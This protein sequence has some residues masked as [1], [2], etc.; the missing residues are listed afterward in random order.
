MWIG[1]LSI[2]SASRN[3]VID[4]VRDA[5]QDTGLIGNVLVVTCIGCVD[6]GFSNFQAFELVRRNIADRVKIGAFVL[7]VHVGVIKGANAS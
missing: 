1:R 6:T 2:F 7:L 3:V 4:T 5:I